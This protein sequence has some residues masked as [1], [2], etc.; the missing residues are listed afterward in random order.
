MT[1]A[2]GPVVTRRRLGGELRRLRDGAGLKLDDVALKLECSPS[3]ISRLENGKGIP[4]WRDVRD[5]LDVYGLAQ[6]EER[7][8]L[9]EWVETGQRGMWWSRFSDV[10]PPDLA[11]YLE[12]EWD[13]SSIHAYESRVVHGLLQTPDYARAVLRAAWT[14]QRSEREID[15]LVEVRLER[16]QALAPEHGLSLHCIL[17]ESALYRVI[18]SPEIVRRQIDRLVEHAEAEHIDVRIL[19]FSAGLV[20]QGLMPFAKLDFSSGIEHGLI[21]CESPVSTFISDP[22]EVGAYRERWTPCSPWR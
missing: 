1:W 3:K 22:D 20:L 15:Q 14:G 6:G 2:P 19:P 4:K 16:Q 13:A 17:D 18:G 12:F 9:L 5:M 10:L 21:Y 8:Q 11:T 7:T